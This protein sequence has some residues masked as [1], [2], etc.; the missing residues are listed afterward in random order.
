M[1]ITECI[2]SMVVAAR[3]GRPLTQNPTQNPHLEPLQNP[4]QNLRDPHPKSPG[5][6]LPR[7]PPEPL[8]QSPSAPQ[9]SPPPPPAP[10]P[11]ANM[12]SKSHKGPTP[13]R[14]SWGGGRGETRKEKMHPRSSVPRPFWGEKKSPTPRTTVPSQ[15]VTSYINLKVLL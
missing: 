8:T 3:T 6:P 12:Y 15:H 13:S 2:L 14:W 11:K 5:S 9:R 4:T 10:F 7:T 1:S